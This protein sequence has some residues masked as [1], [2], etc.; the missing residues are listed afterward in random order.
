M[1]QLRSCAHCGE[2]HETGYEALECDLNQLREENRRMRYALTLLD[3]AYVVGTATNRGMG[4]DAM[5]GIVR[6]GLGKSTD[7]EVEE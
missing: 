7:D 1:T 3:G 5:W 4:H 6:R 2:A